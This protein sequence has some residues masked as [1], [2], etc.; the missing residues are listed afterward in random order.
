MKPLVLILGLSLVPAAAIAAE[1]NGNAGWKELA[2]Y[3]P[4]QA[5]QTFGRQVALADPAINRSARFGRAVALLDRQPVT[6]AQIEE[7][8]G[9]FR[10][11]AER[12][13]DDVAQGARFFLGRIAQH[14]LQVPDDEAASREFRRLIAD[15]EAS[16]WAQSAL[17]RLALI[18]IYALN[19]QAPPQERI[20]EVEKLLAHART[21][22]AKGELHLV[23]ANAIFFYRLPA[24]E[25]LPHL[26]AAEQFA[27]LEWSVRSE[28]LVQI[29]ELSRSAG[30]TE[31][32]ARYYALFLKENPR[33][34]RAYIISEHVAGM[35]A[36]K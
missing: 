18:Q 6:P 31:Q 26:L 25:A 33:D 12:D 36:G 35:A 4:E 7:A 13:V 11:L 17:S 14:H 2:D 8:R 10:E 19:P 27:R 5:L 21:S 29:A 16:I 34:P 20:A 3:R 22:S 24:Q 9:I 30:Q 15:H 1:G 32:A 23:M 28:V